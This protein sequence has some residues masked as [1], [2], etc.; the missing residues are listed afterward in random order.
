MQDTD[1]NTAILIL[2]AGTS[3][4]M[5]QIKQLLPWKKT[6]LLG[7]AIENAQHIENSDVFV[8]LGA[9][10]EK[11]KEGVAISSVVYIDHTDWEKGLGSSIAYGMQCI[12]ATERKY[13]RVLIMLCDQPLIDSV[14]LNTMVDTFKNIEKGIVA[15]AYGD[16]VG[17]PTIFDKKYIPELVELGEDE[18][19]KKIIGKHKTDVSIIN[20]GGK[21]IDL[22]TLEEYK[23][24]VS[25][26]SQ[27]K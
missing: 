11:I 15:T 27:T 10:S 9:H 17:V 24:L 12:E 6:T 16:S 22:D 2:A 7:N 8:V 4:R 13:S 20:P 14:Y 19:A 18:G 3:S 5:G 1:M 25:K 26:I 23:N 21:E